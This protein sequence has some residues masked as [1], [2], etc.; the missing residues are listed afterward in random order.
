VL[1]QIAE[2]VG[3]LDVGCMD[4]DAEQQPVRVHRD[5]P[6]APFQALGGILAARAA[7]LPKMQK[8]P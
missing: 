5:L 7:A 4:D 6:L 1:Q 8:A 2:A 3:I